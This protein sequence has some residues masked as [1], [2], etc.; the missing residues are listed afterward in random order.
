MSEENMSISEQKIDNGVMSNA[1]WEQFAKGDMM[2]FLILHNLQKVTADD[3]AGKKATVKIL[4]Y[5]IAYFI[6]FC[7]MTKTEAV[8][9]FGTMYRLAKALG[10]AYAT[11]HKW[12][13]ELRYPNQ[14]AIEKLTGG[15]LKA[16]RVSKNQPGK[17]K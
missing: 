2:N 16:S 7:D 4:A 10:V 9:H 17:S 1:T 14:L 8:Q 3:G 12:D 15:K 6:G 13:D 5:N 11:V